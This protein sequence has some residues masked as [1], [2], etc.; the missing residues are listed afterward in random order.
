MSPSERI[1]VF[2]PNWLGDAVLSLPAL[3]MLAAARP[4]AELWVFARKPLLGLFTGLAH[5]RGSLEAP[6]RDHTN[7]AASHSSERERSTP[8]LPASLT[9]FGKSLAAYSRVLAEL[10]SRR[11]DIAVLFPNSFRSALFALLSNIPQRIGYPTDGRRALLTSPVACGVETSRLHMVLYYTNILRGLGIADC[12]KVSA[13]Q[14]VPTAP[15]AAR[16]APLLDPLPRPL[17]GVNPGAAFGS[18]KRWPPERFAKLAKKLLSEHGGTLVI[19]GTAAERPITEEIGRATP[20]EQLANL[21]GRTTLEELIAAIAKC[22]VFITNDS[23]PMHVAQ[24]VGTP[25]VALFGP[26]DVSTTG[27]WGEGHAIVHKPGACPKAPCLL[28]S[29]PTNHRCMKA[30]EVAEVFEAAT[31][32]LSR[33]TTWPHLQRESRSLESGV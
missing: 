18:A 5:L 11:F 10:R 20:P 2:S 8:R 32:Q 13:P 24:A 4:R 25:L 27:P 30:I 1:L 23:G 22:D 29:C 3:A 12:G 7:H 16:V 28:R 33:K 6:T 14:L 19:F 21:C 15:A 17:W 31:K 9:R 26:T